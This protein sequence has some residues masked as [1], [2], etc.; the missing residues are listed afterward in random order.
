V[1]NVHDSGYSLGLVFYY[2]TT[3]DIADYQVIDERQA[4]LLRRQE[5]VIEDLNTAN[6]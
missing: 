2:F 3:P 6:N 4:E 1:N 5:E